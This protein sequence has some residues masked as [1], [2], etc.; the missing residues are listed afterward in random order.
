MLD[1]EWLEAYTDPNIYTYT[2]ILICIHCNKSFNLWLK[3]DLDTAVTNG[4]GFFFF[5]GKSVL[6]MI[7]VNMMFFTAQLR[8]KV[9]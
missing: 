7:I 1:I 3:V 6:S 5:V 2:F 8:E 9:K 4:K